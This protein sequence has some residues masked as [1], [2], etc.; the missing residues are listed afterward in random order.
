MGWP[1][2][3]QLLPRKVQRVEMWS[4][5]PVPGGVE[6]TAKHHLKAQSKR[7]I[8]SR[9]PSSPGFWMHGRQHLQVA[10]TVAVLA[11]AHLGPA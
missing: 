5:E 1:C 2:P 7:S 11:A 4:L 9:S 10:G 6:A 8:S 3:R